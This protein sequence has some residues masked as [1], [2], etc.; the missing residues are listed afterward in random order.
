MDRWVLISD[1]AI[2]DLRVRALLCLEM[3]VDM[4]Y[5]RIDVLLLPL[6]HGI[7][8]SPEPYGVLL[9]FSK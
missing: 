2:Y 4:K 6:C 8:G 7:L 1:R 3:S 5:R 9:S